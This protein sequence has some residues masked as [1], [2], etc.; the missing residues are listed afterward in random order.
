MSKLIINGGK[1]LTGEIEVQGAK[2]S[3]GAVSRSQRDT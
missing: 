1:R 3:N 2:N